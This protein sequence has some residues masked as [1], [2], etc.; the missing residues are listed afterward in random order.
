M[1]TADSVEFWTM[2]SKTYCKA[3]VHNVESTLNARGRRL[4]SKC[5]DPLKSGY[6]PE[7]DTTP[8]LK[9]GGVQQYQALIGVLR[10][11]IEIGRI[12]ILLKVSLMST[13]LALP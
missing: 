5:R 6:R 10:W 8:E 13:H 2:S 3:A 9:A 7:L 12:D 4:S 1:E 11:A